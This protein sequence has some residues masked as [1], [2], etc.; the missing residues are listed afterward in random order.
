M[1]IVV[2]ATNVIVIILYYNILYYCC[3]RI[4]L[5]ASFLTGFTPTSTL[6]PRDFPHHSQHDSAKNQIRAGPTPVSQGGFWL[7]E[8]TPTLAYK[9]L[10]D[11]PT[12]AYTAAAMVASWLFFQRQGLFLEPDR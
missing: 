8:N 7:R 5:N 1:A 2:V 11:L 6:A 9:A 3:C 12:S 4:V 10:W